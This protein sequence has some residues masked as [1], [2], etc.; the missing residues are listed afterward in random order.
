MKRETELRSRKS[1][2]GTR[3]CDYT[4]KGEA[5]RPF[6]SESARTETPLL[7]IRLI[8]D[9]N[10]INRATSRMLP[11]RRPDVVRE[12]VGMLPSS[13]IGHKLRQIRQARGKSLAVIA[14]LAGISPSYL[15]R[16]ES[17]QRVLDRRSLII[18][19]AK[20][21]EVAP[22]ELTGTSF[23]APREDGHDLA[24]DAIRKTLLEVS[25]GQPGG[26][27]Q[28]ADQLRARVMTMLR[29]QNNA[30][31]STVGIALP[32]L[33]RDLHTTL[34][35]RRD[36]PEVLALL[37]LTHVQGTQAWLAAVGAPIDL[38]WH[39]VTLARQAAERLDKPIALGISG[40]G[41]ALALLS[42]GSLDLANSTLTEIDLPT[43]E[44][45]DLQLAGSLALVS[46]LVAAARQDRSG[47]FAALDYATELA[48]RTGET[49]L[50]G[51][52]FGPANVAVWRLQGALEVGEYAEAAAIAESVT[53]ESLTVRAREAVYWRE[54]GRS[55]AHLPKRRDS[56]VAML[57]RAERISPEH[58]HRHPFTRDTLAELVQRSKRDAT[59]REVRAIAFRA[60]LPI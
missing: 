17:G 27:A 36:E 40:Y 58:V 13:E 35:Q 46:S 49:N 23:A 14:G 33:I 42:A 3:D 22:S 53:P 50:L 34:D 10:L 57:R 21:L 16:L 37:A 30:N 9:L 6:Y 19:L 60:G 5:R 2:T 55:L 52:G 56:A 4:G 39:A 26:A 20:A 41:A 45:V 59:G 11:E 31:S 51:F 18:A 54:Y 25:L 38:S 32:S 24:L 47:R 28:P 44:T 43:A 12:E 8:V 48:G 7:R 15:S 29:D 1:P